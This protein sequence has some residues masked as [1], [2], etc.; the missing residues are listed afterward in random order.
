LTGPLKATKR[1]SE[2]NYEIMGQNNK[3]QV[4]HINRL[5]AYNQNL[6]KPETE[7]KAIKKFP[8]SPVEHATEEEVPVRAFT[9]TNTSRNAPNQT[10]IDNSPAQLPTDSPTTDHSDPTYHPPET[11]RS[12]RELDYEERIPNH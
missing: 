6:W 12:K 9:L 2:L 1:L 10:Q 8:K 4:V 7:N 11:P 3:K 5:K